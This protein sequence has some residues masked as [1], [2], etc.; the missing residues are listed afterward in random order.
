MTDVV[1]PTPPFWLHIA[2]TFAGPCEV[3]GLGSG[4]TRGGRPVRPIP[5]PPLSASS[6]MG[7][8]PRSRLPRRRR[9]RRG[10]CPAA[11]C[12]RPLKDNERYRA[13]DGQASGEHRR[14]V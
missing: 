10:S 2:T 14:K 7:A 9:G 6:V 1:L 3:R 5:A 11:A 12:H 4:I 13:G 8:T